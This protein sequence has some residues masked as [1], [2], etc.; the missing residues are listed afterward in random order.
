MKLPKLSLG[1]I[2]ALIWACLAL[3]ILILSGGKVLGELERFGERISQHGIKPIVM[4]I[5]GG[6]DFNRGGGTD[7]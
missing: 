7:D 6:R 1:D 5:W 4:R 2:L 3:I